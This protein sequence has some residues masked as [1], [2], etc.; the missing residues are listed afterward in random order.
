ML[1]AFA[2][3]FQETI[4]TGLINATDGRHRLINPHTTAFIIYYRVILFIV[5]LISEWKSGGLLSRNA[6]TD[7]NS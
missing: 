6:A 7:V 4:E 2:F 5:A 1:F 3:F